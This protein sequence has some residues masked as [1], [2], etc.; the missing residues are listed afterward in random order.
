[1]SQPLG[2]RQAA[3]ARVVRLSRDLALRFVAGFD[4]SNSTR[5]APGLPNHFAWNLGHLAL[6][7]HRAIERI[8][9]VPPPEADFVTGTGRSGDAERFDTESVCFGSVPVDDARL[10]PSPPRARAIF[11]HAA[12]RLA[13][14]VERA[15]DADLDRLVPWGASQTPWSDLVARMAFHNGVHTGQIMDLRRALGMKGVL[16]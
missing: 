11:E 7:M 9:G 12:E 10:Y 5:Q 3:L 14:R 15:S 1:M 8:D 6:T 2:T 16:G 4:A 13:A